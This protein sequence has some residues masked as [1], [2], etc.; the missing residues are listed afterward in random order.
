MP[1]MDGIETTKMIRTLEAPLGTIPIIA[2]TAAAL[3]EERERCL[4]SGMNDY[5]AKPYNPDFLFNILMNYLSDKKDEKLTLNAFDIMTE[6]AHL[7]SS[8]DLGYLKELSGNNSEFISRMIDTFKE[9][10]PEMITEIVQLLNESDYKAINRVAH[11]AKSMCSY[12]GC[13]SLRNIM[14]ELEDPK[15]KSYRLKELIDQSQIE[16]DRILN[17][18][19]SQIL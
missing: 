13:T 6:E 3:P 16:L 2:M 12:L 19:N 7:V 14:I 15:V 17:D 9:E 18:L 1:K 10:M 4:Q 11:K 8:F 5:I